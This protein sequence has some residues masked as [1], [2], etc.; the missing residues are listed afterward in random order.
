MAGACMLRII[1][2]FDGVFYEKRQAHMVFCY[3]SCDKSR[4]T[5]CYMLDAPLVLLIQLTWL[6]SLSFDMLIQ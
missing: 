5:V 6:T 4:G 1:C 3:E 2:P